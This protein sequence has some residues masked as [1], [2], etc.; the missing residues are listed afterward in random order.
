M[1][2]IMKKS[3]QIPETIE[4]DKNDF[5]E[6]EIQKAIDIKADTTKY[7]LFKRTYI[8]ML[9]SF[10]KNKNYN[11]TAEQYNYLKGDVE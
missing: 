4:V 7:Y 2:I 11:L 3:N 8:G 9:G 5:T 10:M 6:T 1:E